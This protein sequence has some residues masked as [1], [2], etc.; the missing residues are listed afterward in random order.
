[1][2][3]RMIMTATSAGLLLLVAG[4]SD[5]DSTTRGDTDT[6]AADGVPAGVSAQ[7]SG[8]FAAID[9]NQDGAIDYNELIASGITYQ[10]PQ[11]GESLQGDA[12]ARA[13]LERFD[14]NGDGRI[15]QEEMLAELQRH[16]AEEGN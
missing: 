1:M 5:S 10:D 2:S 11:T 4:C 14:A 12:A 8:M 3:Q 16:L 7:V 9:T 6:P 15:T 13:W